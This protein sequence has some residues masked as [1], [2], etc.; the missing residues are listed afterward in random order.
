MAKVEF[1]FEFASTYSYPAAMRVERVAAEANVQVIWQPF[2]L[3]PVFG[4]QGLT[5]SPFNVYEQKGRYMWRDMARICEVDGLEF[6]KPTVFPQNGLKAARI[7][8]LGMDEGWGPD[9]ARAVY[10]ANFVEGALISDDG[11]I[12]DLLSTLKLDVAATLERAYAQDNKDRLK[13]QTDRAWEK[14]LFGAPSF[15]VGDELFWG[16]DRMETAIAW[17]AS[18]SAKG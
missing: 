3:G 17:A 2:L 8:L 7:A 14:G 5:D 15:T 1:W 13:A 11:V 9:F 10:Q 6:K 16:N 18:G 4:K 12:A